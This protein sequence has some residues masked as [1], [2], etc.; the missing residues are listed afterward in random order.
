[1]T[2]RACW[3]LAFAVALFSIA[4]PAAAQQPPLTREQHLQIAAQHL[5]AAGL[6]EQAVRLLTGQVE[7][8]E[9]PGELFQ[10]DVDIVDLNRTKMQA[11][12]VGFADAVEP[13]EGSILVENV[14]AQLLTSLREA[15]VLRVLKAPRVA[16]SCNRTVHYHVGG[17]YPA[18][19]Q[20][21][22]GPAVTEMRPYGTILTLTPRQVG[23]DRLR[24]EIAV[25]LSE[26]MRVEKVDPADSTP[27]A[28]RI[29]AFEFSAE[30]NVGETLL[31]GGPSSERIEV[32]R[33]PLGTN[34][35]A[36]SEIQL[37]ALVT[38]RRPASAPAQQPA[39][40]PATA[41]R[42]SRTPVTRF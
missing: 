21:P 5:S 29:R 18:F 11:L 38:A 42:P 31:I 3:Q 9:P 25:E 14:P 4:V 1:M 20:L 7:Q 37:C 30:V 27:P 13:G 15:N 36:T 6:E 10:F 26:P 12:G 40:V 22:V 28:L 8:L 16:T 19:V 33:G 39:E 2:G 35:R 32:R 34:Q 23:A 17:S 41:T 24:I